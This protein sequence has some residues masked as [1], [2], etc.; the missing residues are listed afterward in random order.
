MICSVEGCENKVQAK[1][2]CSKHYA[3]VR[4]NGTTDTV[5]RQTGLRP[6]KIE[7]CENLA[8]ASGLCLMHY[9]RRRRGSAV[10]EVP[11]RIN[12][13]SLVERIHRR[14]GE[15]DEN[16]CQPWPGRVQG[17]SDLP[18]IDVGETS[19]SVRR[20]LW[21]EAHPRAKLGGRWVVATCTTPRCV[22]PEHL[23]TTTVHEHNRKPKTAVTSR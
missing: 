15:P 1:G 12:G 22:A 6:C 2:M 13:V 16:G 19:T 18:Y 10:A 20:V 17:G 5:Y 8:H 3:R 23:R 14:L 11:E 4:R 9:S 7:G 21:Q